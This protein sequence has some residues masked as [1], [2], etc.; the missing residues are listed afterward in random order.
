MKNGLRSGLAGR[1][2]NRCPNAA[3]ACRIRM[4]F[5]KVG[6]CGL[7]C[8]KKLDFSCFWF[9]R[10]YT[11]VAQAK[12]LRRIQRENPGASAIDL[13]PTESAINRTTVAEEL[14]LELTPRFEPLVRHFKGLD[15]DLSQLFVNET[16]YAGPAKLD[17]AAEISDHRE[18]IA[19]LPIQFEVPNMTVAGDGK[20]SPSE[21]WAPITE[22]HRF[23]DA[24]FGVASG[25]FIDG[26]ELFRMES[27][28]EG[29]FEDEKNGIWGVKAKQTLDW[30]PPGRSQDQQDW[31]I[32]AW[33]QHGF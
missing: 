4:C 1:I 25:K 7:R 22:H 26:G 30:C 33:R 6:R 16:E 18:V 11:L 10:C 9:L 31:K 23:T 17:L 27:V 24:Q 3:D 20:V 15:S 5:Q 29:R 12:I 28:F 21:L 19:G 13:D 2:H 14:I 8:A 32:C